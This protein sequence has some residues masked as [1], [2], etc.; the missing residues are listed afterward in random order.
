MTSTAS[1]G[2]LGIT[3]NGVMQFSGG[4]TSIRGDVNNT[5]GQIYTAGG[6]VTTFFDD[7][8]NNGSIFTNAGARTIFFGG[9]SG[10]GSLPGGGTNEFV[11][12]TRPGNSPASIQ[13]GGNAV[14][15]SPA[16]LFIEIGGLA[17][18]TQYDKVNV[19]GQLSLG[20][21]L[22]VSLINGFKPSAG[23]SFDIMDWGS[24]TGT[25]STLQL[26]TL[27]GRIVWDSSHLYEAGPS[28]GTLSVA[29]TYYTGDINR[30]SIVDVADVSAMMSALADLSKYQ[31]TNS[32]SN[33]QLPL[34]A[35]LT[36]DNL[37]NN[38]DLQGLINLLASGGGSGGGSLSAVP[39][40]SG[41]VLAGMA[42]LAASTLCG[43]RRNRL[44]IPLSA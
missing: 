15:D 20:G 31:S 21:T 38:A 13:I 8:T 4:N 42:A 36:G 16:H 39:E 10:A 32:L 33:S 29:A 37:V 43:W 9:Y 34:V 19:A 12:D 30:D 14:F 6:S 23:S 2:G 11:G 18:G 1:P 27:S 26:P 24:L 22:N 5:S 35:D 28:G 3:N 17:V 41:V 44:S 7:V 40:P 25:F